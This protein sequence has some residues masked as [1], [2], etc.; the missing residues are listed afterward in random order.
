MAVDGGTGSSTLLGAALGHV[1]LVTYGAGTPPAVERAARIVVGLCARG[2]AARPV[3]PGEKPPAHRV[4]VAAP[5]GPAGDTPEAWMALEGAPGGTWR[6]SASHGSLLIALATLMAGE[7]A[8]EDAGVFARGRTVRV[9]FPFLRNMS[10]FLVGSLRRSRGFSPDEYFLQLARSGFTHVTING[11]GTDRPFESGPPGDVY[12][13][14][15]DYSPDI[16]QF[17]AS[18]LTGGMYPAEYL[19]ANLEA[20]KANAARADACGL[21]PGLHVSSPRSMPEPFWERH[22]FLRG[23]RIDHPRESFR[24]RYTLALAHPAVREHYRELVRG[25]LREVPALGFMHIWTNDSG[26]GFEFVGSLY[27]GRNG[28]PYM[29]REWKSDDAIARAAAANVLAYYRLIYEECARVNPHFRLICDLGSFAAER[30]YIVPG[31]GRGIDAGE[32]GSFAGGPT[33]SEEAALGATGALTHMKLDMGGTNVIGVPFPWLLHERLRGA[34][35]AET[36]AVLASPAP[37][38]MAPFDVNGE[39]LRAFQC[40]GGTPLARVLERCARS[41]AG[42]RDAGAL[43]DVWR[44]ADAA[45]RAFPPGVPL[46]TFAYPWF[47]LSVRPFVADIDAIDEGERAYYEKFLLATFNN[48][49]RI[50]LNNDMLWNF[51]TTGEAAEKRDAIDG[52][53]LPEA[54]AA[55]AGALAAAERGGGDVFE[56]TRE[57]LEAWRSWA[58]T[59]RNMCA[60]T[61][62]VHGYIAATTA[63]ERESR[64]AECRA[65][66]ARELANARSLLALWR[67][68]RRA[69]M[70][71]DRAGETLHS[72]GEN[73]GELLQQKIR[74]MELHPDDEPRIDPSFMWR[75]PANVHEEEG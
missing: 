12:S 28:G 57:R 16:D 31:M 5:S 40:D 66:G 62:G 53:V 74:L 14:F 48:P 7:W 26:A 20:L 54:D 24:P 60:W 75:M 23:A 51:L 49:A 59:L 17:V 70:P 22:P 67:R 19:G 4:H 9:P 46:A 33:P 3:A 69:F 8:G 56:D 39:V 72:Y 1:P 55:I 71:V 47:R 52:R 25:I 64:R 73:F 63:E 18:R 6:M 37:A 15:Y 13:W 2:A 44:R 36:T 21:V 41:W 29:V 34:M 11:L 61:A 43:M 32:F 30:K 42:D 10:D 50:D 27:A 35:E 65:M 45:V 68:S 38:S 58:E